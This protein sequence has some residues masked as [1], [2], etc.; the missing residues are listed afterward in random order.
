LVLWTANT[1]RCCQVLEGVHDTAENLMKA[2][3]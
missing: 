2:I 1:E 3:E